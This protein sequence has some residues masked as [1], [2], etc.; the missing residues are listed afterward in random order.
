MEFLSP[1]IIESSKSIFRFMF[2]SI[3]TLESFVDNIKALQ[4]EMAILTSQKMVIEEDIDLGKLEGKF[5]TRQ[6]E[7]WLGKATKTENEANQLL[8]VHLD[9]GNDHYGRS[10][11]NCSMCYHYKQSKRVAKMLD[12][13]KLLINSCNFQ[14]LVAEKRSPF[15]AVEKMPVPSLMG[16]K[17]ASDILRRLLGFLNNDKVKNIAVWGMG[18]VGKTTLVKN[19]N[20]ELFSSLSESFDMV[21]WVQVS[22]ELDLRVIQ[23]Q[24]A[25]R[26]KLDLEEGETTRRRAN[27]LH[28]RLMTKDKLLII[29]DD[30]WEKIDL[31]IVGIPQGEDHPCCKVLLTTRF[32]DVC[33][34]MMID[35]AIKVNVLGQEDAWKLFAESAGNVV[36]LPHIE[37]LAREISRECCGLPLAIKTLGRSMRETTKIELW[38]NALCQLRQSSPF[39]KSIENE[40][41]VPLSLS[42]VSLKSRILQQCF[43]YCCL[44]PEN[45]SIKVSE[46]IQCWIAEGLIDENHRTIEESFNNGIAWVEILK[47]ACLLDHGEAIGTVKMHDVIRDVAIWLSQREVEFGFLSQSGSSLPE[48]PNKLHKSYTRVSFMRRMITKLPDRLRDSSGLTV[49]FLQGNH[50]KKIPDEFFKELGALRVLNLSDTK[51]TSLPSSLLYLHELRALFL[52]DCCSLENLPPLDALYKLQV[53]DLSRTPLRKLP[54]G[55][56]KL[57]NLSE[58]NLSHTPRLENIEAGIISGLSSL[59]T[60]DMSFSAFS[61]DPNCGVEQRATFDEL[62]SLDRLSVLHIRLDTANCL[63]SSS[64]WLKTLRRFNIQ[65]SPR[66]RD[67]DYLLARCDEKRVILRGVNL[68]QQELEGLLSSAS[69]LDFVT[70]AGTS[71]LSE[72]AHARHWCG[73]VSLKSLTIT[74]CDWL[75]SLVNAEIIKQTMLPNLEH[76]VL[77]RLENLETI[78][79]GIVPKGGCLGKLKTMEV[80]YCPR[81]MTVI[82]YSLLRQVQNIE[83]IKVSGCE[84]IKCIVKGGV[85]NETLPHLRLIEIRDMVELR[86]V[87]SSI[88]AWPNLELIEVSKCP[89]LKKLPRSVCSSASMTEI[90]GDLRWWNRLI[91]KDDR[92]K[93]IVQRRFQACPDNASFAGE[94][95]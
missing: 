5:P 44:Y 89:M 35:E 64:A 93:S 70:C 58:L 51:I 39:F 26:L 1:F 33:R 82:S 12:E 36:S 56:G 14:T 94:D 47:D 8:G 37:S 87:C 46:L 32:F 80:L 31:D 88:P 60:L 29:L 81:L 50:F 20:N 34:E 19:L 91:W 27:R 72:I 95:S 18:G 30:V 6:V 75:K 2:S 57:K 15:K 78:L 69:A 92:D 23:F 84:R 48:M 11:L 25:E 40:V 3:E 62:L 16:Q 77:N 76:L 7:E 22:K 52:G 86:V 83:E 85:L 90:R 55:M 45:Y 73:L 17:A 74:N 4:E 63:A 61:W 41:F 79:D 10:S 21:I 65:I 24:I 9:G 67:S 66:P 43:L 54:K 28:Q 42:Y 49:L 68:L 71:G 13:V 53:L 38:K 59:E